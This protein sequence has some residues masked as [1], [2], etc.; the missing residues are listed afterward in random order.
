[1][2]PGRPALTLAQ[3]FERCRISYEELWLR[4]LALGGS[5]GRLEVEAYILGLLAADSYQHNVL[6][7]ALN[8]CFLEQGGDHPVKYADPASAE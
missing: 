1:V 4:Q 6:A 2:T 5:A 7:Q 3:G 8:E